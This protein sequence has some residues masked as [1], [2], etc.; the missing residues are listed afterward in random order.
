MLDA[1]IPVISLRGI[2]GYRYHVSPHYLA[3]TVSS[4]FSHNALCS[5][6]GN[7]AS[8]RR[9]ISEAGNVL[10]WW[11]LT[12]LSSQ[13]KCSVVNP[14]EFVISSPYVLF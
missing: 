5:L 6:A 4:S 3:P 10:R 13:P 11:S 8:M 1:A 2:V 14:S 7:L 9:W 12:V